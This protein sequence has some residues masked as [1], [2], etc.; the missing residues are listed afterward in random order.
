LTVHRLGARL[1]RAE[2]G[3]SRFVRLA[4]ALRRDSAAVVAA[5]PLP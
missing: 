3:V 1:R 5:I 2:T 4:A